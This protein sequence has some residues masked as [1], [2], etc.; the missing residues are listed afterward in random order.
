MKFVLPAIIFLIILSAGLSAQ[1]ARPTATPKPDEDVVKISTNLIQIDVSVTDK[2]GSVVK[3]LNPE[4]F[5]IYE[6]GVKQTITNLSF[7]SS[8]RETEEP[9]KPI[10][11]NV[12]V[13]IPPTPLKPDQIRRTVALVV[14]DLSLSFESAYQ[15]RRALRKFVDEQM[16]EGDLVAI[17]RTGAGIGALQ[18]FTSDKRILYAAIERVKWNPIG[19]NNTGAF[20]PL[21]PKIQA[22]ETP[23]PEPGERTPEGVEREFNDFRAN[24]FATGTLGAVDYVIRGMS[25]LPGRKSIIL[26]SQGFKLVNE[27]ALGFRESSIIMNSLRRLIDQANRASVV[28]YSIDPRGLAVTGITAADSTAGRTTEELRQTESDRNT[29]LIDTQD[30]L[31]FLS[32]ETGGFAVVNNNDI[33]GGVRRVL[34]DQSYYLIAYEPD[35]ETFDAAKRRFNRLEVRVKRDDV[36]VRYRSGFFNNANQASVQVPIAK[37]PLEQ[38]QNA[39]TSP[40]AVNGISLRLNSLFANDARNGN[41]VRSLIHVKAADL[42]FT[43][44]PNGNKKA[45]FDV[46]AASFGDNGQIVDQIGRSYIVDM[47]PDVYRRIVRDGFVYHF[48]FPVKKPGAY[49]YRVAIRDPQT[50][51]VGSASQFIEIPNLKKG[52]LTIS[53]LILDNLTEAKWKSLANNTPFSPAVGDGAEADATDPLND[54][55]LRTFKPG[56]VL[57]YGYEIYNAK[58]NNAKQPNLSAKVRVFRD[59]KIILDGRETAVELNGQADLERIKASGALSLNKNMTPGDYVLQ[60]I[61]TD[62]R[63]DAKR[64]LASQFIQFEIR[65]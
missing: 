33:A 42:K 7:I 31:R 46:L 45:A 27:D 17:I 12:A 44:E 57:R 5:E 34:N 43:D 62:H 16:Q 4:D 63:A 51:V 15:T 10:A 50:G 20:A 60:V 47:K 52:V 24:Y 40:F 61:V 32:G 49:Q 65:E 59:G 30:G 38:I 13:P 8:V 14:D 54:T 25:E 53:S 3:G 18:Q 56:T 21:E 6:N 41:F 39:L 64:N 9:A 58:L 36:N 28:I 48:M 37:T 1:T 19:N 26:F 55:A 23:E 35:S 11:G 2:K 22:E 29:E